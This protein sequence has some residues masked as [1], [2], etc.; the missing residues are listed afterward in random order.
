MGVFDFIGRKYQ[1]AKETLEKCILYSDDDDNKATKYNAM[2]YLAK[3]EKELGD[4]AKAKE[5]Y[6]QVA[7]NHPQNRYKNLAKKEMDAI[8]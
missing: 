4:S 1:E 3:A 8:G 6:Y 5:Y 7:E 2:Y